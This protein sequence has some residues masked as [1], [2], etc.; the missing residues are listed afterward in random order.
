MGTK[1][2]YIITLLLI[3]VM[4]SSSFA[5][6]NTQ[7]GLPEGAIARLGKGGIITIRFSP[8]GTRLVVGTTIG[9][10]LYDVE[11]GEETA[12]HIGQIGHAHAL[13]FSQDR[14]LLATCG[15]GNDIIQ[16]WDLDTVSKLNSIKLAQMENWMAALAFY[17]STLISLDRRG[18]IYYW[19]LE[20]GEKISESGKV[21]GYD[22]VTFSEDGK[23]FAIGA[24]D[25]KIHLWDATSGKLKRI[26]SGQAAL[27]RKQD[28][29]IHALVFSPNGKI[30]ASGSEDKIVRLWDTQNYNILATLKGHKGSI[31]SLAF[32]KNGKTLASG[33]VSGVIKV[34]D[35]E[36]KKVKATLTGHKNTINALTFASE[37][38]SRFSGCL[39]SGS[40]DGTIRFWDPTTEEE[41][42]TFTTGH[43]DKVKSVAF[44]E[45]D[46]T[47]A[48][49]SLNG[50]VE[51]WS[52]MSL[53]EITT[54][55]D[56]HSDSTW[57]TALSP[58]A[59]YFAS[60][61]RKYFTSQ[62]S[63]NGGEAENLR[64]WEIASGREFP[65]P[66]HPQGP[67]ITTFSPDKYM[68]AANDKQGI[69]I[70]QI[71]TGTELFHIN[72][73]VSFFNG[74]L[75]FSPDGNRFAVLRSANSKPQ[76][77]DITTQNDITPP[78]MEPA[79]AV[80]FSPDGVTL[81]TGSSHGINLWNLNADKENAH[82]KLPGELWG[83]K[84]L[85]YS[86]D[87]TILVGSAGTSLNLID[88][89]T[90][91]VIGN[92][93]GHTNWIPTLV[94]SHNG[95]RLATGSMDGTVILWDWEKVVN[96]AKENGEN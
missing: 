77:W 80:A 33:D 14:N 46:T 85:R 61:S 2:R 7:V 12:R 96:K 93:T 89:Q 9:V 16:L 51:I 53:Q 37:S 18:Q 38:S 92:L 23:L 57:T 20:T 59:K 73:K 52:L 15:I 69:R 22:S 11:H 55:T 65:I 39:A 84:V 10:W 4:S 94:F 24:I 68:T 62:G 56:G 47:L 71:D 36:I 26:L 64:V 31:T 8:D 78:D 28:I 49:A 35:I 32:S 25:R 58:D 72:K 83:L 79:Q 48:T 91:D 66:F 34:W 41:I 74:Q 76:V 44:F 81:A 30:L 67:T 87:G 3:V 40:D 82:T 5:Q 13:A 90:G 88:V 17:D 70:W 19:N 54:F 42:I 75:I 86:P 50:T 95:E 29:E 6:G 27:L 43:N 60:Q 1:K 21:E 63:N 45:N